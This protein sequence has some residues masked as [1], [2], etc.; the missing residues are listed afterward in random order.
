M[1]YYPVFLKMKGRRA[2]VIG[3]GKVAER[4]VASLIKSG[5]KISVISPEVTPKLARWAGSK[6][7]KTVRRPYRPGDIDQAT[8]AF[9]A[10]N[11]IVV[12]HAVTRTAKQSGI[13]IN[14]A[15]VG[16]DGDFILPA[17][18][19]KGKRTIAVSTGGESPA[20]AKKTRD[21]LMAFLRLAPPIKKRK[22]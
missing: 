19:K 7:I 6:K 14:R 16:Q 3:G 15:D 18:L 21:D 11:D 12:N 22:G 20:I 2:V 17:V 13:W 1:D 4:K 5:A 8:L 9:A 10:T